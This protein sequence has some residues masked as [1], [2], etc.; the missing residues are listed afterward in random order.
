VQPVTERDHVATVLF[1]KLALTN[2]SRVKLHFVL[3]L[4]PP[5][6]YTV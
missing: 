6:F 1:P 5:P 2:G 3:D 4:L